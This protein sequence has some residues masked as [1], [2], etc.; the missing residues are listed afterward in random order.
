MKKKAKINEADYYA[1]KSYYGL[2]KKGEGDAFK[3][4]INIDESVSAPIK[5]G[6]KIGTL[7]VIKDGQVK[8]EINLIL[9]EDIKALSYKDSI[10]KVISKW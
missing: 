9:K 10:K 4:E 7:T 1:E 3:T 6:D 5:A 8:E 2:C